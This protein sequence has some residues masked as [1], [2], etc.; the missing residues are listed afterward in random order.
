M[1]T[2]LRK[3]RQRNNE[4]KSIAKSHEEFGRK[5][6]LLVDEVDLMSTAKFTEE[7][8]AAAVETGITEDCFIIP[9]PCTQ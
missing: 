7:V 2:L 8:L 6:A 5:V 3:L 4:K 9:E 1:I